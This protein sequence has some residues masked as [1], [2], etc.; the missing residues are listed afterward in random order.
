MGGWKVE[1]GGSVI[2]GFGIGLW[3]VYVIQDEKVAKSITRE[4]SIQNKINGEL[5]SHAGM[6]YVVV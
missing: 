6:E 3:G 4:S 1:G 2:W 5:W